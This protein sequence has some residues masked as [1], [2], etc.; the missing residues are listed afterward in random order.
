MMGRCFVAVGAGGTLLPVQYRYLPELA[1][2]T[3]A[4]AASAAAAGA[5]SNMHRDLSC[6]IRNCSLLPLFS[7]LRLRPC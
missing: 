4:D 1:E 5:I 2:W 3:A 6:D 7:H